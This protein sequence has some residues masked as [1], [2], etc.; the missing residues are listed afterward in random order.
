MQ[1]PIY[2]L[3]TLQVYRM[4]FQGS[5][6]ACRWAQPLLEA[7][8]VYLVQQFLATS[9]AVRA[10]IAAAWGRRHQRK[11]FIAGLSTAQL[12]AAEMQ[13]WIEAAIAAGYLDPGAGQDL[14]DHYRSLY[15][16]LDQLMAV[17]AT[18][19]SLSEKKAKS[20]LPVTA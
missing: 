15:T 7:T 5:V 19:A 10:H 6:V 12:A 16:A 13:T 1:R 3:P 2:C 20:T 4:A 9:Q 8:D 18:A 17:A 14:Y 11:A